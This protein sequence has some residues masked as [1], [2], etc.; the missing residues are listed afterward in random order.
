MVGHGLVTGHG[1]AG[2]HVLHAE[3]TLLSW[4]RLGVL[5]VPSVKVTQPVLPS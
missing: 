5:A 2:R 1:Q 3:V 4:A